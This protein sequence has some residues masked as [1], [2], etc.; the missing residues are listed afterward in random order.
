MKRSFACI[1]ILAA[2][3]AA[4]L[5]SSCARDTVHANI[6]LALFE[7]G[8]LEE[9]DIPSYIES[10]TREDPIAAFYRDPA[11]KEQTL[12][13]F[14]SLAKSEIV[15]RAIL[16][17]SLKRGVRP[18]LAFALA[19]E[20]SDFRTDAFNK[21]GDSVDRGLFQLNSKS[22]PKLKIQEFYDPEIN[23]RYGLAHLQGCLEEA[24]NEVAALAMYNAGNNRVRKG[25]TPQ[26]TLDY[27]S[28]ILAYE[29]NISSLFAAKVMATSRAAHP[30]IARLVA[31]SASLGLVSDKAAK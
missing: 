1:P 19:L 5:L 4:L 2:L 29:D 3:G 6:D 30:E 13:F 18:S 10:L 25:S 31:E 16:D 8:S 27:I 7:L 12:T 22:F 20:E 26:R 9:K 28:R 15:A 23:A 17:N 21:N 11:T 14:S 24:G